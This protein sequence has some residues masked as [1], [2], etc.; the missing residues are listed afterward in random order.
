MDSSAVQLLRELLAGDPLLNQTTDFA[1]LL[2]KSTSTAGGL[3]LVGTPTQEPWHMAAHLDD[4]SR[5]SDLPNLKPTLIRWSAPADAPPHLAIGL[6]RIERTS[7]R[8]TLFVVAQDDA[9][10]ELLERVFDARKIGARILTMGTKEDELT[11]LAHD[12]LII[13]P[14]N[15]P[16]SVAEPDEIYATKMHEQAL[17]I[18]FDAA[19]HLVS[20]SAGE[21]S[22]NGV[23]KGMKSRLARL[24]DSITGPSQE[25]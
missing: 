6:E 1:S 2:N 23:S 20:I 14:E 18:S 25:W 11:Q 19:Q 4:E 9:P 22:R 16:H 13:P 7:R 17:G 21:I 5:L 8:E 12:A 24:I 15:S 10:D 3:L